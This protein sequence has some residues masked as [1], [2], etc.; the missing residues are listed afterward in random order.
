MQG[1]DA[2]KLLGFL[3]KY[4]LADLAKS[5]F[6]LNLW[7]P[8]TASP[9]KFQYLY[10]SLELIHSDLSQQD[11]IKNYQDFCTFC[12]E[13][14][15][16]AP[17]FPTL[18]DYIPETDWNEIKFYYDK[19]FYKIL[20]GGDLLNPYDY[21]Y[22]F[23]LIHNPFE[24][25]YL[26][27]I[28]RSPATEMKFCLGLQDHILKN[29]KQEK[30]PTLEKVVP[31]YWEV[32]SGEFWKEAM[33]FVD[34]YSPDDFSP[35]MLDLY[36]H[37]LRESLELPDMSTFAESAFK[38]RNCCYFFLKKGEKIYPVM[39]RRWLSV[40]YDKWGALLRDNYSKIVSQLEGK[41]PSILIGIRLGGFISKRIDEEKVFIFVAPLKVDLKPPHSLRYTAV[42]IE[43]KLYLIYTTPPLFDGD[44]LTKHLEEV[45]PKLKESADLVRAV[46]T[47]LAQ[48]AEHQMVEFRS[49][50]T[51]SLEPRFII[52]LP[53]P[54]SDM[55]GI[56]KI[57]EGIE[58][59]IMT[60]DQVAGIFDEIEDPKDLNDFMEYLDNERKYER[61]LALNSYLD[62]F[63]SFKSSHGVLIPGAIEPD[64]IMLDFGWG[65]NHRLESLKKFWAVY[66]E[67][68]LFGHPRSW[69]IP[70]DRKTETGMT[71]HSKNF[72]GY[73]YVQKI[74]ET[75]FF[76][77]A[78]VH[79]MGLE[80]GG[81]TDT[82]MHALFDA[83]N[84][85]PDILSK[86]DITKSHNKVQFFFCPSTLASVDADLTH[87]KH[88]VQD[89]VSWNM[90]SAR[91]R[92]RDF[93]IRVVFNREKVVEILKNAKDRSL[94]IS[95][96]IDVL[97]QIG[98]VFEESKL[99]EV[100]SE[101]EKKKSDKPRFG[102]FS[103][104]KRASFPQHVRVVLPDEKEY[105]LAD[106]EVARIA[107]ELKIEPR[108]Y[109]AN[110]AKEKLNS[111]RS[112]V[113]ELLDKR[114]KTYDF[115]EGMLVLF[116]KSNAVINDA[117]RIEEELKATSDHDKDY[118][119]GERSSEKEKE[120]LHWY[121]VYRYI[122]EKFVQHEPSGVVELKEQ[123]LKEILAL[124]DRLM[125]LYVSSDFINYEIYPV[126]VNIDRDFI[127]SMKDE[128]HDISAMEK[129][130]GEEQA[131]INLGI[132]GK[133]DDT[134][135][136]SLPIEGYLNELDQA[137]KKDF[138]F[139]LKN[140]INVQQ[141]LALWAERSGIP[142]ATHYSASIEEIT[143][144]CLKEIIGYEVSETPAILNFLTLKREGLLTIKGDLN[145]PTD[146][147]VWEHTKRLFR[148]DIRP[149]INMEEKYYWA[150]HSVER[151]SR[152]WISISS[153]HK[154]PSDIDA[155]N[156]NAVL[157]RGHK[158]L[159]ANIVKK[160]KEIVSRYTMEVETDVFPHNY[161]NS[162]SDIGDYDV[163]AYIP[164]KNILLNLESKII[165]PPHSNKD[166]GRVQRKI[167]GEI[168]TD[169]DF[170]K[171][172]LQRVEE[173]RDYL[174]TNGS[175]LMAKLGWQTPPTPPKVVSL[176][177]TKIG[178]WWTK[179]PPVPTDVN[180]VEIRM[181]D[182]F[183]KN[184]S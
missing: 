55:E 126:S 108:T 137:F 163:I 46:P 122:I 166:S 145:T 176:F 82:L 172:Y 69:L 81:T 174:K 101:L 112:K 130:Y 177:V 93:G 48:F 168:K 113:V 94:Q 75:I 44:E 25:N 159:E 99:E 184:L 139:G 173:R 182:H 13:L 18:E 23:D 57:P 128:T 76:I 124:A 53:A 79:K 62:K 40:I 110:D 16:L 73:A 162:I 30:G 42:H 72:F 74:G 178:F 143:T 21:Y 179:H 59:E 84:I 114:I 181:L 27:L 132:M 43:D 125:D 2:E 47:R 104:Q 154:L 14:F 22:S 52:A 120:F 61:S 157:D 39:P 135:D 155:P 86:L 3:R 20:Y 142:E 98:E 170:K 153:K 96:L 49:K 66:P 11:Q 97:K 80:E 63:G 64:M 121:R 33:V 134:A 77:N 19:K 71:L 116:E 10:K 115:I 175:A 28:K 111:L 107:H 169:G 118:E 103:V 123:E 85:Y 1:Y 17:S 41:D 147:P 83:I 129:E 95:L 160:A 141:V 31:G 35:D 171:G 4:S 165:D 156:V 149:L 32:P 51:S 131:Q 29:L 138:G 37:E 24:Q 150:P 6:V 152:I 56:V 68:N 50:K 88:L 133:K 161:D 38:G 167:F 105:K 92:T 87:V 7:L 9:I 89:K 12:K 180:F 78:P 91:I 164:A 65:S 45:G 127:V 36:S 58:A 34:T 119:L 100:I 60:L 106:K 117:W 140:L 151:T 183:I 15:E 146:L 148:F 8:N 54:L 102:M 26:D 90:D 5:F 136:S 70:E 158:N 109:S 144:A 67:E